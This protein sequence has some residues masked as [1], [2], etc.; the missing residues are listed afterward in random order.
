MGQKFTYTRGHECHVNSFELF[1]FQVGMT[2]QHTSLMAL[3]NKK[4]LHMLEF[5]LDLLSSTQGQK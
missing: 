3:K 1:F 5:I 2:V 4:W